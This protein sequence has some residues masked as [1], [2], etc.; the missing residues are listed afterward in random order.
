MANP[1]IDTAVKLGA[2]AALV[3]AGQQV[4]KNLSWSTSDDDPKVPQKKRKK[5]SADSGVPD[6]NDK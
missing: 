5:D 4:A 1:Y 2:G 6:D 3:V